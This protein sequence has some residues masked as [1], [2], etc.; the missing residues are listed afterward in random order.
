MRE[1]KPERIV[2]RARH[3]GNDLL[4]VA[5]EW[6]RNWSRIASAPIRRTA[7]G[8]TTLLCLG[9]PRISEALL[10]D[11]GEFDLAGDRWRI[12]EAKTDGS[13]RRRVDRLPRRGAAARP[14][15]HH[16]RTRPPGHCP[17][18]RCSRVAPGASQPVQHSA[19]FAGAK[20]VKKTNERRAAA[21]QNVAAERNSALSS[22]GR[23]PASLLVAAT[24]YS[25]CRGRWATPPTPAWC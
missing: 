21:R 13:A 14:R 25:S 20:R 7:A 2:P 1:K 19:M 18:G 16:G 12:P 6:E 5:G 9:G 11:R 22:A 17:P 8:P 10:S 3:A 23:S 4:E 24:P 15:R